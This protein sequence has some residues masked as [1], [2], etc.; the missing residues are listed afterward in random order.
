MGALADLPLG[1]TRLSILCPHP[2]SSLAS[3]QSLGRGQHCLGAT[4]W[5]VWCQWG[6][7][8][9]PINPTECH[10]AEGP[11]EAWRQCVEM[12]TKWGIEQLVSKC[13]IPVAKWGS[14]QFVFQT[15]L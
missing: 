12:V 1:S 7:E 8:E 14:C 3:G 15:G 4:A 10:P 13:D 11:R 2:V 9:E 5:A 6:D